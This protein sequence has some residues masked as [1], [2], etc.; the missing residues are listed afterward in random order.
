MGRLI[1]ICG[2]LCVAVGTIIG[3]QTPAPQTEKPVAG[4]V[5][6]VTLTGCLE[7]W[8]NEATPSPDGAPGAKAP[9]GAEFV[10]TNV[11]GQTASATG[12]GATS[13]PTREHDARYLLLSSP[14]MA[15]APHLNHTVTVVGS[16]TP[17]PSEGAS[18]AE[19]IADPSRAE[20]NLPAG[21]RSE[22]YRLN[23][24]EVAKMTMVSNTCKR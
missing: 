10:L 8:S 15:F 23:L 12:A 19:R 4:V 17:Q 24:V 6:T 1:L 5:A 11:E 22:A 14:T 3:A 20:T 13:A 2:T 21:P 7:R 16:I 18:P 9:A